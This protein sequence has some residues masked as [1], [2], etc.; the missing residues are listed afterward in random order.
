MPLGQLNFPAWPDYE[1]IFLDLYERQYYT[2]Q[3]PLTE[4]LEAKLAERLQVRHAICVTN[5]TIGLSM[6][7]LAL[8]IKGR[9]IVPAFTFI[10]TAQSLL[11]S[12]LT[13][14]FCDIDDTHHFNFNHLERLLQQGAD[15]I[16]PVNLW[17]GAY[18]MDKIAS[19]AQ[20]YKVPVYFDSAHGFGCNTQGRPL[21]GF[22]AA[23]VF[24]FHATKVM[25]AGEGGCITTNDDTLAEQLR[26][27]RSSYGV[28]TAVSVDRTAN[29]RMS[30]AQAAISLLNL[31]SLDTNM[32]R[33]RHLHDLYREKLASV[34]GLKVLTAQ[35]VERSNH[36]YLICEIDQHAFGLSRDL[37]HRALQ[38]ENIVARRYFTPGLHRCTP[39]ANRFPEYVDALPAT[40]KLC[41]TVL[42]LPLGARVDM[43]GVSLICDRIRTIQHQ[44]ATVYEAMETSA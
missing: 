24:S 36:Q 13:P 25:S 14:V 6:V 16:L 34:P 41:S 33:N 12:G 21:G 7:A 8:G 2:N 10:G 18:D 44:A 23:E 27:I 31:E 29:G 38:S 43:A 5:A 4:R 37:L 1:K 22:G 20:R 17:G 9:V 3:G 32:A 19:L 30:E 15:A 26:N 39:F 40:D 11:W 35:N 28:R 42:Q